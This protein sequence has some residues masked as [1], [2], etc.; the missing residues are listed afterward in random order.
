MFRRIT[1]F[2]ADWAEESASTLKV[3]RAL[4]DASLEQAI[5]P[6][7][8][9]A[10]RLAWHVAGT[11]PEMMGHAGLAGVDGPGEDAPVPGSAAE[12]AAVYERS[13]RSLADAVAAQWTDEDLPVEVPMYGDS[14][15]R[16]ATLSILIKHQAHHRAQITVLMRQAGVPVPGCYGPSAEEWAAMGM[17]ALA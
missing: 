16:G 2:L 14:W 3:L 6:G 12:I 9:S 7:G 4:T 17:P 8:R 11:L 1:D 10:G 5:V 13:A 15:A